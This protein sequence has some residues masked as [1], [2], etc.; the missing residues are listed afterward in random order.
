VCL[1]FCS[2][3]LSG[4]SAVIGVQKRGNNCGFYELEINTS[5]LMP[6]VFTTRQDVWYKLHTEVRRPSALTPLFVFLQ[7]FWGHCIHALVHSLILFWFPM[8]ALEHGN[9]FVISTVSKGFCSFLLLVC[10]QFSP[11]SA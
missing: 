10:T 11:S 2:K 5:S 9:Y 1:G 3:V 6:G 4:D 8:K 7:V